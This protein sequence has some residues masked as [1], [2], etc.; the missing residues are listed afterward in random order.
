MWVE[1]SDMFAS[2]AMSRQNAIPTILAV[3]GCWLILY[4]SL[5]WTRCGKQVQVITKV[6]VC[7]SWVLLGPLLPWG[8]SW[9]QWPRALI[10]A[11]IGIGMGLG[12]QQDVLVVFAA[13]VTLGVTTGAIIWHVAL[14]SLLQP[15]WCAHGFTLFFFTLFSMVLITCSHAGPMLWDPVWVPVLGSLLITLASA[16]LRP[17][18]GLGLSVD[19]LLVEPC[20]A[21]HALLLSL[22]TWGA[23]SLVGMIVNGLLKILVGQRGDSVI[24]EEG[25]VV[26]SLLGPGGRGDEERGVGGIGGFAPNKAGENNE[27]QPVL[28][29]AIYN[30]NY[31]MSLLTEHEQRLV[32]IC[33]EDEF[34]R[35]RILFG[36]GLQ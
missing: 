35:D 29:D 4:R 18:L 3:L 22:M 21:T 27:R 19:S 23:V 26:E 11:S 34:Q 16:D 24:P 9:W 6:C 14:C 8:A 30:L 36:G 13:A 10:M 33:R 5:I 15:W 2:L 20:L 17:D 32:Q 1:G 28:C 7:A 31:D 25:S 12:F